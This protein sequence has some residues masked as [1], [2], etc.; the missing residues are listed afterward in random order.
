[1]L[2]GD[3]IAISSCKRVDVYYIGGPWEE[4]E[5]QEFARIY[6]IMVIIVTMV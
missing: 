6:A 1:M 3:L 5:K 2:A 4:M